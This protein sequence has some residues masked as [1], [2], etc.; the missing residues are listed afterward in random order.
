MLDER[1]AVVV[2]SRPLA[3]ALRLVPR[4]GLERPLGQETANARSSLFDR[5]DELAPAF[6]R[7]VAYREHTCRRAGL[8]ETLVVLAQVVDEIGC[9]PNVDPAF[10]APVGF[11]RARE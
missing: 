4:G 7:D 2:L 3:E 6:G 5:G 8:T 11:T 1:P 10:A 9:R